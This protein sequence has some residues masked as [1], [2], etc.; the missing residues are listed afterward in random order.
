[1][2]VPALLSPADALAFV[3]A[4]L[5]LI[6]IVARLVGY[7]FVVVG[8]PRV[9]GE[10][11]AGIL[12]GPTVLGGSLGALGEAG[13]GLVGALYPAQSF[14]F[15]NLIGQ[16]GLVLFMFLVGLELDQR[17]LKER[18]RQIVAVGLSVVVVPVAFG[19]LLAPL[20]T[21]ETWRSPGTDTVTFALFLGAG[22]S[23]TAFPVMARI[24]QEKGLDRTTLGAIGLGSAAL[25]TVLMFFAIAAA[26]AVASGD[27]AVGD[28]ALKVGL[29]IGLVLV[30]LFVGRPLTALLTRNY[31]VGQ[32]VTPVIGAL[33]PLVLVVALAADRIGISALVGGFLFGLIVPARPGMAEA[34]TGRLQDAIVLFFLPVFLAVSGIRTDLRQFAP[35]AVVGLVLFLGLMVVGKWGVGYVT[36]RL[37]GLSS[38]EAHVLGVLLNCRGLLI[39][40]VALIG[41]QLG[42]VTPALQGVFVLGAIVTTVMTGPIV[43]VFMRRVGAQEGPRRESTGVAAIV[44]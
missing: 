44:G 41:Q 29:T 37:V 36:A 6:L 26:S 22:L 7:L 25:V 15:L 10:I 24:L 35:E 40:V 33:L 39:L 18:G 16:V 32:P 3:L 23:V 5:A 42:V 9:V 43:E 38:D 27:G 12:I 21:G 28:I 20:L 34:V 17:L 13:E 31:R 8:Q 2:N 19:F 4:D 30:L 1:M 11:V 14:A